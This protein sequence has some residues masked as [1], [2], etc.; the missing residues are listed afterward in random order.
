MRSGST[1]GELAFQKLLAHYQITDFQK[2]IVDYGRGDLSTFADKLM[3]A[4][5][6]ETAHKDG[7]YIGHYQTGLGEFLSYTPVPRMLKHYYPQAKVF[8]CGHRF[9]KAMFRHDPCVDAV[10]DFP[11]REPFGTYREF[12]F[13]TH[14]QKRLRPFG[15]FATAPV[16]PEIK[17]G[18]ATRARW[19]EW[20]SQLPL[21]G[22]KLVFIQSSGRTNPNLF[23][24][25][26]WLR[27]LWP[28]RDQYY[29]VQIGNLRDQLVWA[30][31]ILLKLWDMEEMA[32]A[33][34]QAD[35]FM[36][37]NSGVMHLAAAVGVPAVIL[38]NEALASEMIFPILGDN[39]KLPVKIN[40]HLFHVYPFHHHLMVS[41]SWD[42][43]T[44]LAGNL[45]CSLATPKSVS[46]KLA[47]ACQGENPRWTELK[48]QFAQ[49][50]YCIY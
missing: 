33:L 1:P 12:G 23:S 10:V 32:A 4:K 7:F 15:I 9:A 21:Q 49:D 26:T 40:G 27:F 13:G 3:T 39:A 29:F 11:D 8:V 37:P 16:A 45:D 43:T 19:Q 50:P 44:V 22:R 14:A 38:H 48:D 18:D 46:E 17:I 5:D 35:A 20:R 6:I 30:N 47:M 28:L 34:A 25:W 36:G 24:A 41:R 31:K 2:Q 42:G